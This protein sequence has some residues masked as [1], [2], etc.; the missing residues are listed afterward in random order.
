MTGGRAT[1]DASTPGVADSVAAL[2]DLIVSVGGAVHPR[3]RVVERNGSLSVHLEGDDDGL[4]LIR[5]PESLLVPVD[6]LDWDSDPGRI[7]VVRG[8]TAL[9]GEQQRALDLMLDVYNRTGKAAWARRHLPGCSMPGN[10]AVFAA[11]QRAAPRFGTG[12][13]S[14]AE[15][16]ISSRTLHH[17]PL[18]D[19]P[20]V[21]VLMPVVDFLDHHRGGASF[22]VVDGVMALA[23]VRPEEPTSCRVAYGGRRSPLDTVLHFGFVDTSAR[24]A[25]SLGLTVDHP[26]SPI[27]GVVVVEGRPHRAVSPLDPPNISV[28]TGRLHL[29]H[30]TF[31]V[32]H[33]DRIVG[34]LALGLA[35]VSRRG[36]LTV[37]DPAAAARWLVGEV[38]RRNVLE[39]DAIAAVITAAG[40]DGLDVSQVRAQSD[41]EGESW[42][43][44]SWGTVVEGLAHHRDLILEA[45]AAVG[46]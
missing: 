18:P 9:P 30:L 44:P 39:L 35:G 27:A 24:H 31:D 2:V 33:P 23:V 41:V 13:E 25:R 40:D 14:V 32:A 43:P 45:A 19:G 46:S 21:R 1:V 6:G 37:A 28:E 5:L 7:A 20:G 26:H 16:F 22:R 15:V 4:P 42:P 3:M 11:V 34:M 8:R 36:D 17:R 12:R 10:E 38:A 29:S